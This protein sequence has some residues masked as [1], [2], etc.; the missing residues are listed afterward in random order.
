VGVGVWECG[1]VGEWVHGDSKSE[2]M[3]GN[4]MNIY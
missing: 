4:Y 1:G 3:R 2:S